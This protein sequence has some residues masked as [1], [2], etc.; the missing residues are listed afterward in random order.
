MAP[1]LWQNWLRWCQNIIN[2]L[3]VAGGI[4]PAIGIMV[5][6]KAIDRHKMIPVFLL[7]YFMVIL[8]EVSV[9]GAAI[10]GGCAIA[11]M[12]NISAFKTEEQ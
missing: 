4:L 11:I 7:G 9:I 5:T 3:N 1:P 8:F 10:I 2:G 6:L 12:W